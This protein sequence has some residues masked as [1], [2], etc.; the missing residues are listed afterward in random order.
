MTDIQNY[1]CTCFLAQ[2]PIS[3]G[4]KPIVTFVCPS[5]RV[6]WSYPFKSL[7]FKYDSTSLPKAKLRKVAKITKVFILSIESRLILFSKALILFIVSTGKLDPVVEAN[8]TFTMNPNDRSVLRNLLERSTF[9][10]TLWI[11][12]NCYI[13]SIFPNF[14][15]VSK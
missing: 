12:F 1:T 2:K 6:V 9:M 8:F 14:K 13:Q 3:T 4:L 7:A 10:M 15:L 5:G 11:E